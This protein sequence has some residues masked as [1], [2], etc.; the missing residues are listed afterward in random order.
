VSDN[1]KNETVATERTSRPAVI[2]KV[3]SD[4]MDKTIIVQRDRTV[5][6]PLYK[7]YIRRSTRFTAHDADN[8]A[9]MGDDVEIVQTRPISKTKRWRLVRILRE[10]PRG[11]IVTG[12]A[13]AE[14]AADA[15]SGTPAAG[16]TES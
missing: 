13:D 11:G 1:D 16:E 2:G 9:H 3:V 10:A 8:S 14:I 4:K 6:H 15:S 7:K 5:L 12:V